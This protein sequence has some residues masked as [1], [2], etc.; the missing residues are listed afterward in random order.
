MD[1]SAVDWSGPWVALMTPFD[2]DGAIDEAAFRKNVDLCIEYGCTGVLV[3]GCTGEFW[4]Q[5]MDERKRLMR[6]CAEQAAGR[7][8]VIGGASAI[9]TADT[10]E[11]VQA[12]KDAG[13]DGAMV[14]PPYFV[15]LPTEDVIAHYEAVSAAVSF[16]IMLYNIPSAASVAL[17]PE[18]VDRLA[19]VENVVAIKESS[20]D[21][22]NFYK[23]LCVAGDRLHVFVGPGGLFGVAAVTVGAAG[24]VEGNPN[25][26]PYESADIYHL[27]KR[28]ELAKALELQRKGVALRDLIEANGRNIYSS[29][30]AAMNVLGLP[31]GYPRLPL[32][33]LAESHLEEL[34]TGLAEIGIR[35]QA[36]AREPKRAD[37]GVDGARVRAG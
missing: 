18:L 36:E 32:R 8:T 37:T 22:V 6:I 2:A 23:T 35:G 24:Y 34:R 7:A 13:C 5:N 29:G 15:R 17:V 11:L 33:P 16:P 28:G 30:K 26:W 4:A 1:K 14:M 20:R 12:A 27:T 3:N 10:I 19:D 31:G 21:F 9:T 25:Y